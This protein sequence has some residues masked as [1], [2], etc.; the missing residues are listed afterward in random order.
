[1]IVS[2]SCEKLARLWATG[3]VSLF[4]PLYVYELI[5]ILTFIDATAQPKDLALLLNA[6]IRQYLLGNWS[7]A[8]TVNRLEPIGSVTFQ[9]CCQKKHAK[10]VDF[11]EY[12]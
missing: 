3:D 5:D 4:S 6:S 12:G 7:I 2:F 1:M 10:S 9:F 11:M 8:V